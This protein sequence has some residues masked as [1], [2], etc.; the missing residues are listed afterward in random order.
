MPR[1]FFHIRTGA[2]GLILDEV[3]VGLVDLDAAVAK[4]GFWG[5]AEQQPADKTG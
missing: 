3:A 2:G 4:I 1:Y 5:Q